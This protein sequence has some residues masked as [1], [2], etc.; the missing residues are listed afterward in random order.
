MERQVQANNIRIQVLQEENGR[1]QSMLSKI[2]EVA[3]QGSLK[4]SSLA[5]NLRGPAL[6]DLGEAPDPAGLQTPPWEPTE[7]LH[8]HMWFP[9]FKQA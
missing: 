5:P 3:Q 2:R 6:G 9:R 7:S 4:V 1:L 8:H